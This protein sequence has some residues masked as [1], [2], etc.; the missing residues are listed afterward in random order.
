MEP[1]Y[2]AYTC[3]NNGQLIEHVLRLYMPEALSENAPKF[4]VA[5]VTWGKGTFWGTVDTNR[6]DFHRSDI[7]TVPEAPYDF[8]HLPYEDNSFDLLVLDPPYA[9]N[10][11]QMIVNANYMNSETTRGNLFDSASSGISIG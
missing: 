10:P 4:R 9:H 11:G 7:L 6:F 5:D 1:V 2:T 3:T 8:R